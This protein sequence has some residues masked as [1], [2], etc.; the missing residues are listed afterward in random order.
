MRLRLLGLP[1]VAP[2]KS[3]QHKLN[4]DNNR[5]GKMDGV[6]TTRHQPYTKKYR[7]LQNVD[8]ERNSLPQE[9]SHKLV[10]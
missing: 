9:R 6:K 2:I 5:N 10:I 4:T 7:K 3:H 1:E 8:S